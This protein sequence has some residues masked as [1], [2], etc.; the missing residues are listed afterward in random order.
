[1]AREMEP[2]LHPARVRL[3]A[4]IRLVGEPD[5]SEQALRAL[6]SDPRRQLVERGPVLEV[7]AT[8]QPPVEAALA[9]EDDADQRPDRAGLGDNVAPE[10][11]RAT[12]SRDEH[13]R[14]D[15]HERRL[16]RPV[17][18]EQTVDLA[19]R[20]RQRDAVERD[21][22]WAPPRLEDARDRLD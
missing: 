6:A 8:G 21:D 20:D 9:A 18:P 12:G 2:L 5:S 22:A 14:Q 17:R 19:L 4:L 1:P 7:L 16:A 3:D 15:L 11:P 10:D 13:R